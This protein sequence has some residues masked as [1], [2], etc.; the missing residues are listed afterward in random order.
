MHTDFSFKEIMS[1]SVQSQILYS[2]NIII[3]LLV[4]LVS[5]VP[6]FEG[7]P[8]PLHGLARLVD[9]ETG[10]APL[11]LGQLLVDPG[12]LRE[13]GQVL[14][15]E[16]AVLVPGVGQGADGHHGGVGQ[17]GHGH[18]VHTLLDGEVV[19]VPAWTNK[20]VLIQVIIRHLNN[21]INDVMQHCKIRNPYVSLSLGYQ[22][23][24]QN[25]RFTDW[26]KIYTIFAP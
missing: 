10:D 5:A 26:Q 15:A 20:L 11:E 12:R 16:P 18:T 23:L 25:Y 7:E 19:R 22:N 3:D 13:H 17:V 21:N 9:V 24:R 6:E 8:V 4:G 2:F 14:G 1:K